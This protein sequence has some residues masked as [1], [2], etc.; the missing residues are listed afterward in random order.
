MKTRHHT[1]RH[2]LLIYIG[3][4]CL[5]ACRTGYTITEV[6]STRHEIGAALDS[7]PHALV[8]E[9]LTFYQERV[10]EMQAPVVGESTQF[11]E[12][13]R[14]ES[15][16]SNLTAD[17]LREAAMKYEGIP[18]DVA[19]MNMG[20]L[21]STLPKGKI[22]VGDIY[23]IFPF[24]NKLFTLTLTGEQLIELFNRFA[25]VGGQGIS[26][27]EIIIGKANGQTYLA[28]ATV[29]GKPIRKDKSYR[30]ATIDY[31]AEGNDGMSTLR[32]GTER[33][34]FDTL[35]LRQVVTDY[36]VE[37]TAAGKRI[38]SK[39]DNRIQVV[40]ERPLPPPSPKERE[41]AAIVEEPTKKEAPQQ[42]TSNNDTVPQQMPEKESS[43]SSPLSSGNLPYLTI[44][45]TSDTHS[46]IEPDSKTGLGGV[47]R[48]AAF[49]EQMRKH[50]PQALMVDCGDFSQ[51]SLYYNLFK[52]ETEVMIM[53]VIG[54]DVATIGNHEF[55]FG[56]DN[57]MRIFALAE[58]PIVSTN[59]DFSGTVLDS[60]VRDYHIIRTDGVRIGF[61]GVGPKLEGLVAEAN[62]RG[63]GY[64]D[65]IAAAD[66]VAAVLKEEKDCDVVVCLSHLGWK[67]D[68]IDDEHFIQSTRHI[69]LVL[70]GHTHSYFTEPLY[71]KN[72]DGHDI[73][74]MH[75]GK[76]GQYV[77]ETTIVLEKGK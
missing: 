66:S 14:P 27:A 45:H 54:Y 26:G 67:T 69:D 39:L 62:C 64:R 40:E 24:E 53:N 49:V 36:I 34:L 41:L 35:T 10:R 28:G 33:Q 63:V 59:Y 22:T 38:E 9:Y 50:N 32:N 8:A 31:L 5:T 42:S 37:Q 57:M 70:G 44:L 55:D 51:G 7:T 56:L 6:K 47:M 4:A 17:I 2:A 61:V 3:I 1:M 29:G 68:G 46:C 48:R 73:L 21:R 20:G 11:M 43:E 13:G 72:L 30:V 65:P 76:N 74:L 18:A 16:L 19:V 58:F 71:Y 60:L 12:A 77:S 15:L 75:V 52:G 25:N 23:K